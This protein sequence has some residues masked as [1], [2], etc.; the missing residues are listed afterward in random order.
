M[1]PICFMGNIGCGK[2]TWA[3]KLST[4]GYYIAFEDLNKIKYLEQYWK[5]GN[6]SFHTQIEFYATWLDLYYNANTQNRTSIIDSSIISHHMVFSYYMKKNK[7]ISEDEFFVCCQLYSAISKLVDYN[8]VYLFCDIEELYHRTTVRNR[9][10]E[11]HQKDFLIEIN[12]IFENLVKKLEIPTIDISNLSP[13][14]EKDC[15]IFETKL[16]EC[17]V[18]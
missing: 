18:I 7:L 14:N 16:K 2:S 8:T 13:N 5:S 11:P 4:K 3:T 1:K 9:I 10:L 15:I 17:G 6:F 12:C